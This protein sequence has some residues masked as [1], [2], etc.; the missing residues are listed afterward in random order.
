MRVINS[1]ISGLWAMEAKVAESYLPI[2][3]DII[4]NPHRPILSIDNREQAVQH[5]THS[6]VYSVSEYGESSH[7]DDAPEGSIAVI[8]M[9]GVVTKYD[10]GSTGPAGT[11]T[12]HALILAALKNPNIN[13]LILYVDS[14]GG[15]AGAGARIADEISR[16]EKPV[17]AY[18]DGLA[19]SAMYDIVRACD[20]IL[21]MSP[22]DEIGSIGTYITI[23]DYSD[24]LK[25][26]G[27]KLIELYD[28]QSS[29]KN[30]EVREAMAGNMKPLQAY[31]DQVGASF[32]ERVKSSRGDKITDADAYK[33]K[34][35]FASEALAAGLI[36]GIA[37]FDQA[38]AMMEA[39][40]HISTSLKKQS[41][42]I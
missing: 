23:A 26:M 1:I 22:D 35:Y 18:V 40:I 37:S 36:D 27:I 5:P 38:V 42:I 17:Y 11:M 21:A 29:L 31:V 20:K 33:G 13:G 32:R 16:S 6:G 30:T 41:Y 7:P 8:G 24:R 10:Q 25:Q 39:D 9:S 28:S 12:K 14:P 2:V 15:E 4:A 34:L 3:A 19:A